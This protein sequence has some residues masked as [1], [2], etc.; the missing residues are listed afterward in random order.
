MS[1]TNSFASQFGDK[2]LRPSDSTEV[3]PADALSGKDHVMLYFS[4]HWCG[5]C[6][7]FTPVLIEF[8][9]N[10]KAKHNTELVFCSLD[11]SETDHKEYVSNMPW[12][13]MPFEA[14]ESN[15]LARKYGA[16][17]IPHLVVV[18]GSTGKVVA[19]DGTSE[20]RQDAEGTNFPWKPKPFS[21]VWPSKVL[22]KKGDDG[23]TDDVTMSSDELR[24]KHL[25]LYFSAHWC[26]PCRA[27]TPKLSKAYTKL[28]ALRDDDVELVF[29]SSDRNEEDFNEYHKEMSFPALPFEHRDAKAALS[30]LYEVQGI[31]KLVMLGPVDAESGDRPLINDNV[32]GHMESEDFDEFPFTKRNYGDVGGA[33]E[34]NETKSL[35]I[36]H[37]NGDDE[38]QNRVKE[39]IKAVAARFGN[40]EEEEG[41]G[42]A[43]NFHWAFTTNGVAPMIREATKLPSADKSEDPAMILLDIPDSGAYYKSDATDIT[44]ETVTAFVET[45]G[46]RLQLS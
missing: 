26:P 35:I 19:K 22:V 20:V 16:Q 7:Q 10:I 6:R 15:A 14:P 9:K 40:K 37:E 18:D 1:E 42:E 2:L 13:C 3:T 25:M 17:G 8:Y 39:V 12:V 36:F 27:F 30:K 24:N 31:P 43:V 41:E 5:P 28:K 11:N 46:E 23:T 29:V 45:P 32:R 34:L 4:A 33:D 38:E 21:E 44:V